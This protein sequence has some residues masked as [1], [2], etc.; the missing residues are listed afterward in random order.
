MAAAPPALTTRTAALTAVALVCFSGNSLLCRAAL[1]PHAID[2][3]SFTLV[4]IASGALVLAVL[5]R[6]RKSDAPPKRELVAPFALFAYAIAFSLAYLRLP[7]GT[8]ALLLFGA[9]QATMLVVAIRG[10]ERPRPLAWLGMLLAAGGLVGLTL[11]GLG[12][13]DPMSAALMAVAGIAWGA[14]T[15]RGRGAVDPIATTARNFALSVPLAAGA[16]AIALALGVHAEPKGLVLAATSGAI[17]SG[18]GYSVWYTALRGL[19]AT[20]AAVL[21][22]SVPVL[23]AIAGVGFLGEEVSVRLVL[24]SL[25]I[26]GGIALVVARR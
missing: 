12:A 18:M 3:A 25:T 6:A 21:Q 26:L 10:G 11:P 16:F 15:L 14:Y 17:A 2:A 20:R 23:T 4:R 7:A 22:L 8:G 5:A 24:S 1:R 9:V 13:P 19:S